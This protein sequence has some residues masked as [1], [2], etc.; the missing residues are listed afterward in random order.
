MFEYIMYCMGIFF[1]VLEM[2]VAFYM[3]QTIIDLGVQVRRLTLVLVAPVLSPMQKLVR[4]S[5]MNTFSIDL[6]PYILL[7]VLHYLEQVCEYL[8]G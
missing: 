2:I 8:A 6:S 4:H 3:F 5:V 7:V 1:V